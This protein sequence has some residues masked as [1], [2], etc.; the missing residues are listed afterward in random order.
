MRTHLRLA[1][2]A[3]ALSIATPAFAQEAED[4]AS[5][6]APASAVATQPYEGENGVLVYPPAY[7]ADARPAN[8]LDMVNRIPGFSI[9]QDSSVR[10]FSGAVGNVLFD[11]SR[12]ASKDESLSGLL[13]RIPVDQVERIELIRGGAPGVDM[14]GYSTVINVIRTNTSSRQVVA[15]AGAFIFD[16]G[17]YIPQLGI[18]LSGNDGQRQY[19]F[20]LNTSTSL[21]D[22]V[23][24]GILRR[25][26][27]AGALV[28][29]DRIE[30]ESDGDGLGARGRWQQPLFG[31]EIELNGSLGYY[32][33]KF[34]QNQSGV[35]NP[36]FLTDAADARYAEAGLRYS[37]PL[38]AGLQ[39]E[40]RFIQ[41]VDQQEGNQRYLSPAVEQLFA[42]DNLS[43]ETILRGAV[44]YERS[45][46]LTFEAGAEGAFNFLD[47]QQALGVNGTPVA[48]PSDSVRVEELRG[49]V[50]GQGTW[51]LN[52]DLTLEG[53]VRIERS[54]ISQSGGVDLEE[55][56]TFLKPRALLT[57]SPTE[58]DQLRLRVEREVGQLDFGDFAAS[59]ELAN[60]NVFAGNADLSPQ[61][62]WVFEAAWERRFWEEGVLTATLV[63]ER[64]SDVIDVIPVTDGVDVFSAPGNIGDGTATGFSLEATIPTDRF[65]VPG[66]QLTTSWQWRVSEV[67]D[68]TTGEERRISGQRPEEFFTRFTQDIDSWRVN[69]GVEYQP[70]GEDT[71]FRI[72]QV[73]HFRFRDYASAWVEYKPTDDWTLRAQAWMLG[74]YD[75]TRTVFTGPRD[76]DPQAYTEIRSMEPESRLQVRVRRTF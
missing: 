37:R 62:A 67:T 46:D 45:E 66:G 58:H 69:W 11:G 19:S 43:G 16:D 24:S 15:Y 3:L 25:Y 34:E 52:E 5:G 74:S 7:F 57:W 68:P 55:T 13:Q 29:E 14:Q 27:P 40:A 48:L 21:S 18:E 73:S 38:G 35:G 70:W 63:H 60:N 50:F 10:G 33:F 6:S 76:T 12:P 20:A 32:D 51:R 59:A 4:A 1:A 44:T 72:D 61:S 64:I 28:F 9:N 41:R 47:A 30:S 22:S 53:G 42:Y 56:F 17:R 54:T 75:Q 26:S 23:G 71:V 39:G 31:G 2:S 36:Y 49:E 8:A 65:G